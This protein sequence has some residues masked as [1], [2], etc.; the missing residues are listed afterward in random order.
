MLNLMDKKDREQIAKYIKAN[1]ERIEYNAK[2]F[3]ILEGNLRD[4]LDTRM[5]Q[6]LGP[7]SSKAARTR[8]APINVF[9]KVV[10][11]LTRIY[12]DPVTRTVLDGNDQDKKIVD[13]YVEQLQL[14]RKMSGNNRLFNAF[15][16]SILHI[17]IVDK[18]AAG[19]GKPFIRS[20][21]NHEFLVMNCSDTDPTS[22]DIV[23]VFMPKVPDPK[24]GEM[25]SCYWVYSKY[26]FVIMDDEAELYADRM[27]AM[28]L[29]GSNPYGE[30][31]F[32]YANAS[33]NMVMPEIQTDNMDMALLIPLLL[34]DL[35]YAVKFQAF[36][37]FYGIDI[38]D[39]KVEISPNAIMSFRSKP[40]AD[41]ESRP[42]F[43]VIKP[44]VD[45]ESTLSLASSEMSLW[46]TTKG[47][48]PGAVGS[49]GADQFASGVAKMIDE[50]D[51]YESVKKQCSIYEA[52]EAA[53]WEKLKTLHAFWVDNRSIEL[54]QKFSPGMKVKVQFAKPEPMRTRKELIDELTAEIDAGFTT[55]KLAVKKLFPNLTDKEI[56]EHLEA[57]KADKA[58][59]NP[60]PAPS[61]LKAVSDSEDDGEDAA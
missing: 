1:A 9:Q 55:V 16:Y 58:A 14:N 26:Q 29:D 42:E 19:L 22:S 53:F 43:N 3:K 2:L 36:S 51:T 52:M 17:Y 15:L 18:N 57:V 40:N 61:G 47:I 31:P 7:E 33:D 25:K 6:D 12:T 35:N 21:P 13:W 4:A 10:D 38:D 5:I 44:T 39:E 60:M 8:K 30:K 37:L 46:L 23:I 32:T 27:V 11:K 45:I 28:D 59:R 54:T 50:S 20:I 48:R 56:D 49:L 24:T 41:G 34:T